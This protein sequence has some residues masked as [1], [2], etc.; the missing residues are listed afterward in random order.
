MGEL[1]GAQTALRFQSRSRPHATYRQW[2]AKF[3]VLCLIVLL[4]ALWG[5]WHELGGFGGTETLRPAPAARPASPV[6]RQ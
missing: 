5:V 3:L 6:P 2:R 4:I 1:L